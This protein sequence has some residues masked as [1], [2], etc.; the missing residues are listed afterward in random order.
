MRFSS[1]GRFLAQHLGRG[2]WR[3]TGTAA[4]H[5]DIFVQGADPGAA[6][7]LRE[8][9]ENGQIGVSDVSVEWQGD[10]VIL[11]VTSAGHA[12]SF[13]T[14]SA[15][16]HEPQAHLYE[17]LPLARFDPKARRFWRRI[18]RLVRIPGGRY[19]LG[20]LAHRTQPHRI[21]R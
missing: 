21:K 9:G 15:I 4:P 19:L 1:P 7:T 17:A 5:I 2:A 18:F 12:R 16:V 13:K 20:F 14:R 3:L 11:T 10:C 6:D 8:T